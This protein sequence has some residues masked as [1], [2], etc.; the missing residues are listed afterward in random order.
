MCAE[1]CKEFIDKESHRIVDVW[2]WLPHRPDNH[3]LDCE[4][5][6]NVVGSMIGC[7]LPLDG[8]ATAKKAIAALPTSHHANQAAKKAA[9]K[10]FAK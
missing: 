3:F 6:N 5:I 10:P 7:R 4:G 9:Y 1:Q 8:H 2:S